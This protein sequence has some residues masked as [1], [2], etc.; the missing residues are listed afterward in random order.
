MHLFYDGQLG[1]V[2]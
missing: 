2:A 1:N